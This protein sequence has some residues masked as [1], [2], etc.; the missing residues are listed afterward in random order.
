M[1]PDY[2]VHFTLKGA[3]SK[4]RLGGDFPRLS[5]YLALHRRWLRYF[6]QSCRERVDG[7]VDL[8]AGDD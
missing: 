6:L 3:L 8:L 2:R 5:A 7:L 4:L 1:W